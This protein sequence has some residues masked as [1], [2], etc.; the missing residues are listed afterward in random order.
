MERAFQVVSWNQAIVD[1]QD[2]KSRKQWTTNQKPPF[3]SWVVCGGKASHM[4]S[5]SRG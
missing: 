3:R 2:P 1:P 5:A 4:A